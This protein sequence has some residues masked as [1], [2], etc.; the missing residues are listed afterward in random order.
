MGSGRW[1]RVSFS[2]GCLSRP[3]L[4]RRSG[5]FHPLFHHAACTFQ[6]SKCQE[7]QRQQQHPA[8][9]IGKRRNRGARRRYAGPAL[10]DDDAVVTG[11]VSQGG[12]GQAEFGKGRHRTDSIR[13]LTAEQ[14][15]GQGVPQGLGRVEGRRGRGD[16][17]EFSVGR[18]IQVCGP[19]IIDL[20]RCGFA[21]QFECQQSEGEVEIRVVALRYLGQT[22]YVADLGARAAHLHGEVLTVRSV[23]QGNDI[24]LLAVGNAVVVAVRAVGSVAFDRIGNAVVVVVVVVVVQDGA[25]AAGVRDLSV[26]RVTQVYREGFVGFVDG[27]VGQVDVDGL[28]G[29]AGGKVQGGTADGGVIAARRRGAVGGSVIDADGAGVGMAQADRELGRSSV[30]VFADV[31][32]GQLKAIGAVGQV[33][34]A[35]GGDA[36]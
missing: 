12:I 32:D 3:C 23:G 21:G 31:V 24:E 6:V 2:V 25:L 5:G 33:V 34:G 1:I 18:P 15:A 14:H 7:T 28:A 26:D 30:L 27:V 35:A 19:V 16:R 9:P 10:I 17:A 29:F 36:A 8:T 20:N 22:R 4:Q 13:L 11:I